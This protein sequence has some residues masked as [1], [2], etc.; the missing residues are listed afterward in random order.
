MPA[1]LSQCGSS[2]EEATGDL[3]IAEAFQTGLQLQLEVLIQDF[4]IIQLKKT[5]IILLIAY[6]LVALDRGRIGRP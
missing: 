5:I 6:L 1:V 2:E 4:F 3:G